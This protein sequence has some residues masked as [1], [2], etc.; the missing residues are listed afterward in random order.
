MISGSRAP[1]VSEYLKTDSPKLVAFKDSLLSIL[2]IQ[3]NLKF[4]CKNY[5]K[6]EKFYRMVMHE[7]L[8]FAIFVQ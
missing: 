2:L 5:V 8:A 7:I 3:K 6:L 4:F 1:L